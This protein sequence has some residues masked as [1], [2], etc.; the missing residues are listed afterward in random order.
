[1]T[2]V[3]RTSGIA[4]MQI[5][6]ARPDAAARIADLVNRAYEVERF[7]VDGDRTSLDE[8]RT[9]MARGTFLTAVDESGGLVGAVLV[10]VTGRSASFGMLAVEPAR[11]GEGVGRRLVDA[12]E[13]CAR[14]AGAATMEIRVVN[15][16]ADL[17]PRYARLGYAPVGEAPYV[18]RP[19]RRPCHFILMAKALY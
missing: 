4:D 13:R 2:G 12:A 11:Q 3:K 9:A 6:P 14:E 5:T 19:V 10:D 7:F 8:V 16:R 1:M 18:D 15:L 17:L